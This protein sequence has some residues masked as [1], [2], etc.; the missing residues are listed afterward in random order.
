VAIS[1]IFWCLWVF[2]DSVIVAFR[3]LELT[4][5]AVHIILA[6]LAR[7]HLNIHFCSIKWKASS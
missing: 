7:L 2:L 1:L 5:V 6:S 3:E 4:L